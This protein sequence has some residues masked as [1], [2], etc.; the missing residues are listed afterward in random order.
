MQ[1]KNRN[2]DIGKGLVDTV[3]VEGRGG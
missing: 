2:I 1:G 3:G